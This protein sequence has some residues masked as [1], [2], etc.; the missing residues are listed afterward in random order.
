MSDSI[1]IALFLLLAM[2]AAGVLHVW[3]LKWATQ[4]LLVKPLDFGYTFRGRRIFGDNKQVRGLIVMPIACALI[5]AILGGNRETLPEWLSTGMWDKSAGY[6][7]IVG[8]AAGLAF[9][10][11]ELPNSF[12]KRQLGVPPGEVPYQGWARTICM[13][14]DRFDSVIGVLIVVSLMVPVPV[15]SWVWLLAIGPGIHAIFSGMLYRLGIKAR[16]L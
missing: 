1:S 5:F 10:L 2:S 9:M 7:A 14:L 15:L 8:G 13:L 4:G 16:A 11:A 3:W 12:I 6:Y